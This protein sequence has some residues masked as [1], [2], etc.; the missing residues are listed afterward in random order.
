MQ[1]LKIL[2]VWGAAIALAVGSAGRAGAASESAPAATTAPSSAQSEVISG[3]IDAITGKYTLRVR[4]DRG[5]MDSVT[6]HPGTVILP[7]GLVLKPGMLVKISGTVAG[8]TFAA[9]V[10][11]TSYSAPPTRGGLSG[12]GCVGAASDIPNPRATP[13]GVSPYGLPPGC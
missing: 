8:N 1:C 6:L 3:R 4:D 9:N 10:I 13:D 7:A 11:K 12:S 2:W 5:Y